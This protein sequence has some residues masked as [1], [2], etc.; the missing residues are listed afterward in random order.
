MAGVNRVVRQW[1]KREVRVPKREQFVVTRL[2]NTG[3][4]PVH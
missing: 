2:A 1:S 3:V 4:M